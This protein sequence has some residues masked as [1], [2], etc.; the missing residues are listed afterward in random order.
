MINPYCQDF[1]LLK[2]LRGEHIK[3]ESTDEFRQLVNTFPCLEARFYDF[4]PCFRLIF[5]DNNL[6]A[7]SRYK[8]DGSNYIKTKRGWEAPHLVIEADQGD[9]SLYDPFV[10]Y[11]ETIWKKSTDIKEILN[12]KISTNGKSKNRSN[13]R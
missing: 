7:I 1:G 9:W 2:S 4:L 3:D 6:L 8:L 5:M 13:P 12:T 10:S 11:Y